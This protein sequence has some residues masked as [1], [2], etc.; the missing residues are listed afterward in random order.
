MRTT[1]SEMNRRRLV[2][3]RQKIQSSS[4]RSIAARTHSARSLTQTSPAPPPCSRLSIA[5][6]P[7]SPYVCPS[8]SQLVSL[9][10]S[11]FLFFFFHR[12]TADLATVIFRCPN[13]SVFAVQACSNRS[14]RLEFM[15]LRYLHAPAKFSLLSRSGFQLLL[16]PN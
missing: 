8:V 7:V 1:H 5:C 15:I 4:S 11:I 9:R 13:C 10:A 2:R 6:L 3:R 12:C 16:G 14:C